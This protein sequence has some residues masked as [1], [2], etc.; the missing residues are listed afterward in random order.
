MGHMHHTYMEHM[1]PIGWIIFGS[2]SSRR[3]STDEEARGMLQTPAAAK[4]CYELPGIVILRVPPLQKACPG[5][6]VLGN[7]QNLSGRQMF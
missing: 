1:W 2:A 6:Q 7:S 4:C 3:T 5:W